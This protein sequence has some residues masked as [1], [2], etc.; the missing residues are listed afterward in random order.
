[1]GPLKFRPSA[2]LLV[3]VVLALP[4]CAAKRER[5]SAQ[6]GP[7]MTPGEVELRV[8]AT[9]EKWRGSRHRLGG[10]TKHGIDCSAFVQSIYREAFGISLP[11]TTNAMAKAGKPVTRSELRAGDLVFFKPDSYPRHVGIYL[12]KGEFVH[13]SARKGVMISRTDSKY[14]SRHYWTA[15][16]ILS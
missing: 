3:C 9:Y 13:V 2:A 10:G 15:R 7:V 11:R 1:M 12:G 8:R 14:W 5:P 16:R 4:A 6:S